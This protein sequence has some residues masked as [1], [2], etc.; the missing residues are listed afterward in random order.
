MVV[1]SSGLRQRILM[2]E[3]D[4]EIKKLI[5]QLEG[6]IKDTTKLITEQTG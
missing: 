2:W 1:S 4:Y 5:C 3:R 6:I